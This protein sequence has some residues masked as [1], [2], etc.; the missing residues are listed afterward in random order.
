MQITAETTPQTCDLYKSDTARSL[1]DSTLF[2]TQHEVKRQKRSNER[3]EK[4]KCAN[5]TVRRSHVG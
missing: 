3:T 5:V 4:G 1:Y 2:I